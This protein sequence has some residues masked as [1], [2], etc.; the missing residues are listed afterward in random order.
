MKKTKK[1]R[2]VNVSS[3][4]AMFAYD[5]N[6]DKIV[7]IPNR[8]F[9]YSYSKLSL[10]LFTMQL[11]RRLQGTEVTAYSLHPG[12]AS[13]EVFRHFNGFLRF[14]IHLCLNLFFKVC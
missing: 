3:D 12:G 4:L 2:I 9:A 6:I 8:L 11:A 14:I 5:F 1:S 13:T 10:I 7:G